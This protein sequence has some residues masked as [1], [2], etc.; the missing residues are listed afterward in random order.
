MDVKWV[1]KVGGLISDD[2]WS[3]ISGVGDS[4]AVRGGG[5]R[6]GRVGG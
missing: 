5:A 2:G 1:S 3:I 6:T 4:R